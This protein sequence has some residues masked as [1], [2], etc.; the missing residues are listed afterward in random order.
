MVQP[1]QQPPPIQ[2]V[3]PAAPPANNTVESNQ[4]GGA[5]G[6]RREVKHD[7]SPE[8]AS[9]SL[10]ALKDRK[11]EILSELGDIVGPTAAS[12]IGNIACQQAATR[13]KFGREVEASQQGPLSRRPSVGEHQ[14]QHQVQEPPSNSNGGGTYG[15]WTSRPLVTMNMLTAM[16][17]SRNVNAM[18]VSRSVD[19]EPLPEGICVSRFGPISR[20]PAQMKNYSEPTAVTAG[21]G[22]QTRSTSSLRQPLPATS[23]NPENVLV[24]QDHQSIL[25]F[26]ETASVYEYDPG[27]YTEFVHSNIQEGMESVSMSHLVHPPFT[28]ISPL[29]DPRDQTASSVRH[30]SQSLTMAA[31]SARIQKELSDLQRRIS[32]L[33][34]A[35]NSNQMAM[36][37]DRL[38]IELRMIESGI[39]DRHDEISQNQT[40]PHADTS[41][42]VSTEYSYW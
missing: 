37:R 13:D 23:P 41:E 7:L 42:E 8:I 16:A 19:V 27:F 28:P 14:Q 39:R 30:N 20:K 31:E 12:T 33:S 1:S 3:E 2:V 21:F 9:K 11:E 32:C 18:P 17:G 6:G 10:S 25:Q 38:A 4:T 40:F 24:V 29:P 34:V 22:L 35:E 5:E 26:P 15:I 36:K